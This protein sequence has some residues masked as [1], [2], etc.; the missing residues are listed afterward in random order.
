[1]PVTKSKFIDD[2]KSL[3]LDDK[4]LNKLIS[5]I[6]KEEEKISKKTSKLRNIIMVKN[7]KRNK[8]NE[9]KWKEDKKN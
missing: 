9:M 5:V 1:M 8:K 6:E 4:T 3:S 7:K 2:V